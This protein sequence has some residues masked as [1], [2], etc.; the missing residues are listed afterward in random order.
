[1]PRSL[2]PRFRYAVIPLYAVRQLNRL[3]FAY[4]IGIAK[5]SYHP[6]YLFVQLTNGYIVPIQRP[7]P[8]PFLP[9][10]R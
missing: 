1:M 10:S 2:R 5:W 3:G 4:R 6:D 8:S 9:F 7:P